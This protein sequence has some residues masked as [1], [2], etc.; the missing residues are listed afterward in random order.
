[1]KQTLLMNSEEWFANGESKNLRFSR[2]YN[3]SLNSFIFKHNDLFGKIE[4]KPRR[5]S[6]SKAAKHLLAGLFVWISLAG[7]ALAQTPERIISL[8][9]NLTE[10]LYD[11]G[12]GKHVIAVSRYCNYPP[13]VKTK[14]IIG[15]MSNPSLEAIVA[16]RPE[17]VVLTDDGNPRQIEDRLRQV[18]IRTHVFRAKRLADL[19][20]EIRALGAALGVAARAENSA[21]RIESVIRRHAEKTQRAGGLPRRKVLFVVQP[22][23]LI[24]AGPGTAIDDVLQLLGL[25]NIAADAK[26]QY[27]RYS[28][29]EVIRQSPDIIFMGMMQDVVMDQSRRLLHRLRQVE[30]VRLGRVHYIGDPL[31]RMGPRITEGIS[32]MAGMLEKAEKSSLEN[33]SAPADG[34]DVQRNVFTRLGHGLANDHGQGLAAGDLH[35]QNGDA[36]GRTLTEDLREFF[37]IGRNIIEF[38]A[39]HQHGSPGEKVLMES[40]I[41]HGGAVGGNEQVGI[42]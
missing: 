20:D 31:F 1:M 16:M 40:R 37:H 19:P 4:W 22:D 13:E 32:E 15:G 33:L 28:L 12:L 5:Y 27:P 42:L 17:M 36:A 2:N 6:F 8:A 23:P 11:L 41:G 35:D 9:P 7:P 14:P 18:G 3:K 24:V 26:T 38:W 39:P 25:K 10:I 30:A 34:H 21:W 29:E